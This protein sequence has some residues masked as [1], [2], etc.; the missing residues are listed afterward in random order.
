MNKT[1]QHS[2][3][4]LV[5]SQRP[6]TSLQLLAV[7]LLFLVVMAQAA[8]AQTFSVLHNFTGG[9]DGYYPE[10]GLT[11]HGT[12]NLYGGAGPSAVFRLSQHGSGWVLNPILEFNGSSE[13]DFLAGR[14]TVGPDCAL[15]GASAYGGIPDCADGAPAV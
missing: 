7:A 5:G 6:A 9:A 3:W 15:Y 10:A 8:E 1:R 11:L 12:G 4:I 2:V 13:G 14:M